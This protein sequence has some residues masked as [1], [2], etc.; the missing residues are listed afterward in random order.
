[1]SFMTELKNRCRKNIPITIVYFVS[2]YMDMTYFSFTP[3]LLKEKNLKIAE[4]FYI[5]KEDLK[6]GSRNQQKSSK[7]LC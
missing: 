1:M 6:S 7:I 5:G 3:V 4:F 2:G